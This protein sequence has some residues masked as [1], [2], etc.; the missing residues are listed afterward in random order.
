MKSPPLKETRMDVESLKKVNP[1]QE[2]ILEVIQDSF[3]IL[4]RK[5]GILKVNPKGLDLLGYPW[6]EL[7]QIVLI[8]VVAL[9]ELSRVRER[10]E[11]MEQ[12]QGVRFRTE[13]IHYLGERI[14]VQCVGTFGKKT[15]L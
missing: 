2:S 14:P 6:K 7:Q 12:G 8:D 11:E 9:E 1:L 3:F 4:D 5:G 13:I 10:F 15:F